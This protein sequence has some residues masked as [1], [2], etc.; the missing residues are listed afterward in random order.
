MANTN[1]SKL[2]DSFYFENQVWGTL[3]KACKGY[4]I[5]KNKEEFDKMLHYAD[6]IQDCQYDLGLEIS[7]FPDIGKSVVDFYAKRDTQRQDNI[8]SRD[9]EHNNYNNNY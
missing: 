5:A 3:H 1:R 6:I 9:N 4:V 7:S 2:L 8:D